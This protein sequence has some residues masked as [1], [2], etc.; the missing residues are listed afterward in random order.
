MLQRNQSCIL[1]SAKKRAGKANYD[2]YP[3]HYYYALHHKIKNRTQPSSIPMIFHC[4]YSKIFITFFPYHKSRRIIIPNSPKNSSRTVVDFS[5]GCQRAGF[6]TLV[7][8][9]T[10]EGARMT[11]DYSDSNLAGMLI[12][13]SLVTVAT[14]VGCFSALPWLDSCS[15]DAPRNYKTRAIGALTGLGITVAATSALVMQNPHKLFNDYAKNPDQ[16]RKEQILSKQ[17]AP[18]APIMMMHSQPALP[19]R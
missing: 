18:S 12:L 2:N 5:T 8:A 7:L 19:A 14:S 16:G 17:L 3:T 9:F 10:A 1:C 15:A 11:T 4:L 13:G 6:T